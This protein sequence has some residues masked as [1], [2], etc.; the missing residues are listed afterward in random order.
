MGGRGSNIILNRR[1]NQ[2]V[3]RTN[4]RYVFVG[5]FLSVRTRYRG[6]HPESNRGRNRE[7]R[8][9]A[10][11]RSVLP[12]R[13]E[14]RETTPPLVG[15]DERFSAPALSGSA[16]DEEEILKVGQESRLKIVVSVPP[17][18]PPLTNAGCCHGGGSGAEMRRRGGGV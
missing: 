1:D 8:A 17:P 3:R 13:F 9:R 4:L 2:R 12:N 18:P 6:I 14:N 10:R 15:R 11:A 16:P 7:I 5:F